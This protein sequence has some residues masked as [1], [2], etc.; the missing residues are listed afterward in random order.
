MI[1]MKIQ[2]LRPGDSGLSQE[3]WQKLKKLSSPTKIQD[4]LNSLPF[5]FER[6]GGTH[7]S[8]RETL[9]AGRAHCFEGAL[10]AAA[11]LR[12]SGRSPLILDLVA[13]NSD[14]DHVVALFK[15]GPYW[16]AIS[17]TNHNVLRYREPIYRSV[18]ELVISYFHEYFLENGQKTLRSFSKP[19]N[20]SHQGTYWITT[21]ENLASLAHALDLSPHT[22]VLT[23]KQTR[24]LRK[25]DKIEIKASD[26]EEYKS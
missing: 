11:A 12:I 19:F 22:A 17:K 8:V 24:H 10:V 3:E 9:K 13:T 18:R 15:D 6:G 21:R 7:R 20:L 16:V 1:P 23:P 14:L 5:N 26:I 2:P 25:A 4:F